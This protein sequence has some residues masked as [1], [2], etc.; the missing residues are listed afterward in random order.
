ML[1]E[2]EKPMAIL[3]SFSIVKRCKQYISV[4]DNCL[5]NECRGVINVKAGKASALPKFSDMLPNLNQGG[6]GRSSP[7]IGSPKMFLD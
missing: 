7:N 5:I 2:E 1:R 4:V 6:M 3:T